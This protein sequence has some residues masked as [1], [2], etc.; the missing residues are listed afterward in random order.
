MRYACVRACVRAC[1]CVCMCVGVVVCGRVVQ[2]SYV[3]R[4]ITVGRLSC[5]LCLVVSSDVYVL[6]VFELQQRSIDEIFPQAWRR[7][8]RS[9]SMYITHSTYVVLFVVCFLICL[10][11][12]VCVSSGSLSFLNR[13]QA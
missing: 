12:C 4:F 6:V 13:S 8:T 3:Y 2:C 10:S 5:T 11:L 1:V 7:G 9:R